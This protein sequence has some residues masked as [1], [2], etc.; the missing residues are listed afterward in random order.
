MSQLLF[1]WHCIYLIMI[2]KPKK[3]T[4]STM[5][6]GTCYGNVTHHSDPQVHTFMF[7]SPIHPDKGWSTNYDICKRCMYIFCSSM[8][9]SFVNTHT[10]THTHHMWQAANVQLHLAHKR[11]ESWHS[12]MQMLYAAPSIR[13]SIAF[14]FCNLLYNRCCVSET[15]AS[16]F[17]V[18]LPSRLT[19]MV[20]AIPSV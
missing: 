6:T 7:C 8:Y 11:A 1:F 17:Y 12:R 16:L 20:T 5:I 15:D 4:K 19:V 3:Y 18:D 14:I 9:E 2:S 13:I 10:H